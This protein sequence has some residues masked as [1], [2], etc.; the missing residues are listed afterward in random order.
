MNW[1]NAKRA[2]TTKIIKHVS[3]KEE[4][5]IVKRWT[6]WI[7]EDW[8]AW[9][10]HFSNGF[11]PC[12]NKSEPFYSNESIHGYGQ[13][14][15]QD[16]ASVP[17]PGLLQTDP[18]ALNEQLV[19]SWSWRSKIIWLA[20]KLQTQKSNRFTWNCIFLYRRKESKGKCAKVLFF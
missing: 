5:L 8:D 13:K 1:E 10:K 12:N 4:I 17:V 9:Q 20:K 16:W 11:Q 15:A 2:E 19:F 6:A 3:K 7:A 18:L 14:A